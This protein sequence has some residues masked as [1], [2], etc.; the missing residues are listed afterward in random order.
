MWGGGV[1]GVTSK[2]WQFM[3]CVNINS[4]TCMRRT[5][6]EKI[7]L[8]NNTIAD[9]KTLAVYS[10][11]G[12]ISVWKSGTTAV[13]IILLRV[14]LTFIL[15]YDLWEGYSGVQERTRSAEELHAFY[16]DAGSVT[17]ILVQWCI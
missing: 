12:W 9:F 11:V 3:L 17:K 13:N 4:E 5:V 1:V 6:D 15:L 14:S 8:K 7:S 16:P 2:R 10:T